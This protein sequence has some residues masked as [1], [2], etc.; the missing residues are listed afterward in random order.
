MSILLRLLY[1][2]KAMLVRYNDVWRLAWVNSCLENVYA[3]R[4]CWP[5][6]VYSISLLFVCCALLSQGSYNFSLLCILNWKLWLPLLKTFNK[7]SSNNIPVIHL[8]YILLTCLQQIET[9]NA[10]LCT[11]THSHTFGLKPTKANLSAWQHS[12]IRLHTHMRLKN[13]QIN[14]LRHF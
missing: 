5:N 12:R 6:L 13:S 1:F 4:K 7:L 3:I 11:Y 10:N 14:M 9:I 2:A 8:K